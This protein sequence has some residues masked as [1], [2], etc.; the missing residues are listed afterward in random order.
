M[1]IELFQGGTVHLEIVSN[2]F[3]SDQFGQKKYNEDSLA[4]LGRQVRKLQ[5]P[6]MKGYIFTNYSK[7]YS[8]QM[9]R[10]WEKLRFISVFEVS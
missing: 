8:D 2:N 6:K 1:H 4:S 7:L 9:C 3:G 5:I 10:Y